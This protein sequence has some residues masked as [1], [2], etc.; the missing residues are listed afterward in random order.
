MPPH[1]RVEDRAGHHRSRT[2]GP[3]RSSLARHFA[4]CVRYF[5]V[6]AALPMSFS[7]LVPSPELGLRCFM[8]ASILLVCVRRARHAQRNCHS[9]GHAFGS[10]VGE[11][12]QSFDQIYR[13]AGRPD[14]V[15][16]N[17]LEARPTHQPQRWRKA[18]CQN[19]TRFLLSRHGG[20]LLM[21]SICC[22]S[23]KNGGS[24][25]RTTNTSFGVQLPPCD[26]GRGTT[27]FQSYR[28]NRFLSG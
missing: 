15:A 14:P 18:P 8:S 11:S 25:S 21:R 1:D 17:W 26:H 13:S 24:R 3:H 23:Y 7:R 27:S 6:L 12:L 20:D 28:F 19:C 16:H 9:D 2:S 22:D 5:R 10:F 4:P